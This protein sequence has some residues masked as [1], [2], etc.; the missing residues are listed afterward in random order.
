MNK[1]EAE[2]TPELEKWIRHFWKV[3]CPLEVKY[4]YAK[5]FNYKS[6]IPKHQIRNLRTAKYRTF[7]YKISDMD[8]LQKPFDLLVYVATGE[9]YFVIFW[10][11]KI[12]YFIDVDIIS[13]EIDKGVKSITEE[14][15]KQ[16]ARHKCL[17]Q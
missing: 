7:A 6:H 13:D 15:A 3:S 10:N 2:V 1:K 8:Q 16:I 9:A 17:L 12:G 14:H 4:S 11:K 5:S